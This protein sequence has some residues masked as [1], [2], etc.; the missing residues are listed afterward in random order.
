MKGYKEIAAPEVSYGGEKKTVVN[1]AY[2]KGDLRIW[3]SR[4]IYPEGLRWHLS[5]SCA[6][7]YPVWDEIRDARY[8]L[9]PDDITMA[10][11]LPPAGEYVNL[12]KNCFHL[13]EIVE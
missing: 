11:L 5:I 7:R 4:E 1:K 6:R 12:H 10:M 9:L 13:H 8:A 2:A 3:I